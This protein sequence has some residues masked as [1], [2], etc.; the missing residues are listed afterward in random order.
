[1]H[2]LILGIVGLLLKDLTK[3]KEK[4]L[5]WNYHNIHLYMPL[6]SY[7]ELYDNMLDSIGNSSYLQAAA[8]FSS[9]SPS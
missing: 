9:D 7:T 1:M 4:K 2:D 3:K 5:V 6:I 8:G